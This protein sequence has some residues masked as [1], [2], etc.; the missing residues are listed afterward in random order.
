MSHPADLELELVHLGEPDPEVSRH[1]AGCERCQGVVRELDQ[2]RERT[3]QRQSPEAYVAWLGQRYARGRRPSLAARALGVSGAL[4]LAA[5]VALVVTLAGRSSNVTSPR[6]TAPGAG[7]GTPTATT[8]RRPSEPGS[9]ELLLRGAQGLSV[10]RLRGE[11]M[12]VLQGVVPVAPGDRIRLRFYVD[13]PGRISAGVLTASG[14]WA[15]FFDAELA[16]GLHTPEATLQV[17]DEPG[18]GTLWVGPAA[19]VEAAKSGKAARGVQSAR[20]VWSPSP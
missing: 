5:S 6:A 4:A 8:E 14:E 11:E 7:A 2:A 19:Q 3:A 17:Q 12:S 18:S 20:I 10:L 9:G 16:A 13:E 15:T 1:V